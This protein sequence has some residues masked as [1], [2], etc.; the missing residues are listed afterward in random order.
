MNARDFVTGSAML[1]LVAST[2]GLTLRDFMTGS[3]VG[4]LDAA[5]DIT[6][7]DVLTGA[8]VGK[9]V[10]AG[11]GTAVVPVLVNATLEDGVLSWSGQTLD[12]TGDGTGDVPGYLATIA[13]PASGVVSGQIEV[14]AVSG[15]TSVYVCISGQLMPQGGPPEPNMPISNVT[16]LTL[17]F[18][19]SGGVMSLAVNG[20][21]AQQ[22]TTTDAAPKMMILVINPVDDLSL[23]IGA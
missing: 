5:L 6:P 4:K 9:L 13:S 14:P 20:G 2:A 11:G 17:D 19:L 18:T 23:T 7:R 8:A 3:A 21:A 1:E 22:Y 15:S 16:A 12:V 10:Q